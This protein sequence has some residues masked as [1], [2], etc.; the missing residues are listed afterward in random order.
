M[1]RYTYK[2][3]QLMREESSNKLFLYNELKCKFENLF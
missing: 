3:I 1:E 2:E